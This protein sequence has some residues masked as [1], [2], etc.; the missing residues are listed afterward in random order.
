MADVS[1]AFPIEVGTGL[2]EVVATADGVDDEL[3]EDNDEGEGIMG[4]AKSG[5]FTGADTGSG[6]GEGEGEGVGDNDDEADEEDIP[7]PLIS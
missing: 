3:E 2:G 7:L 4:G 6:E 5:D 1:A